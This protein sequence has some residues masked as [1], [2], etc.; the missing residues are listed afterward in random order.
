MFHEERR[1]APPVRKSAD[2]PGV[3]WCFPSTYDIGMSGLGYQLIWWLFEQDENLLVRRSFADIAEPG[4][5]DSVLYGFTVSWELDFVEVLK[6]MDR[7]GIPSLSSERGAD[8]PIVFAGGP[9]L[10]A[11]PE[12]YAEFFDVILLGDAEVTVPSFIKN[13]RSFKHEDRSAML[14]R[15]ASVPGLY[16][17]SMYDVTYKSPVGDIEK[18]EPKYADVPEKVTRELFRPPADYVAH[19]QILAP[20]A[21]WGDVFLIEV[22]RSCPQECRFCLASFLTRPFRSVPVDTIVSKVEHARTATNRVGLMGPSITEHPDFGELAERLADFSELRISIASV[23]A[24]TMTPELASRLSALGQKSVTIA[25]ESGSSRL[26]SIMKKN[27]SDEEIVSAVDAI[28]ASG[29]EAIKFYGIVGLPFENDED[30]DATIELL[31]R[32][33]ARQR[34]LRY[35]FGVSSFV[36]KAQTP[37]QWKGRDPG[38]KSKIE[39]IRKRLAKA[40]IDVRPESHNWSDIQALL[41]RGDR[42]LSP[43]LLEVARSSAK[44]GDWKKSLKRFRDSVPDLEYFAYREIGADELLAWSHVSPGDKEPYLKRHMVEATDLSQTV[45]QP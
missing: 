6:Q 23:R 31:L 24:D 33:K 2:A 44:L 17:P 10:T 34:T 15:L 32:L 20:N 7:Y 37:F 4:A 29:L 36:P 21:S 43:V 26:R 5:E 42:R 38:S 28:A 41:S 30:I 18:I 9:V 3:T 13:W 19:S 35:T 25:I 1:I 39:K 11:N 16:V 27:L 14:R 12:P 22:V 40:G 45:S 8:D